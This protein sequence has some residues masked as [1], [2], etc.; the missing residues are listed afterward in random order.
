METE[1]LVLDEGGQG[2]IVEQVSEHFPYVWAAVFS[3]A[4]IVETINLGNLSTFVISTKNRH[5]VFVSTFESNEERNSF[6]RIVT[7]VDVVTHE[8][9]IRVGAFA[10]D[11]EELDEVVKL[12]VNIT[13]NS[14]RATN[15]LDVRFVHENFASLVTQ[16]FNFL[17]AQRFA[18]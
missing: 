12:S 5:S 14:D 6:D 8:K 9:V 11:S 2:K 15:R 10:S 13:A 16:N 7:T 17:F 3:E 1:D 4:F 18:F